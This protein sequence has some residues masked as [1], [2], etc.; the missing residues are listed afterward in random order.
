MLSVKTVLLLGSRSVAV[1]CRTL[2]SW[3][4]KPINANAAALQAHACRAQRKTVNSPPVDSNRS[5]QLP[6]LVQA[7][8]R[9]PTTTAGLAD[10]FELNVMRAYE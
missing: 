8:A 3:Q 4:L 9:T 5:Q 7:V 6:A 1:A 10:V 2:P